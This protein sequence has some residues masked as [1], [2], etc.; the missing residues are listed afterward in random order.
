MRRTYV[1]ACISIATFV[2]CCAYSFAL[3]PSH[4]VSQYGHKSWNNRDGFP[5]DIIHA[6]VQ[7][8]D[9]YLWLGTE[10]GLVRFDG[11]RAVPWQPPADQHLPSNKIQSLLVA[12]DGTLWIGT[13]KGL[14]SWNG[15]KLTLYPELAEEVIFPLIEDQEG[16][17]WAGGFAYNPPGKLCK[18]QS[19]VVKCYGEDGSLGNGVLGLY[20]DRNR[21]LWVGTRSGLWRWKPGPQK[22]YPIEG[23]PSGIQ[24]LTEDTGAGLLVALH[25]RIARLA[26]GKL[27]T[28][29]SYPAPARQT[30]ARTRL[31]DRDGGLWFGT[32][33]HGLVHVHQ[34]KTDGF[35]QTEGLSGDTVTALFED[36]EGNVWVATSNGLDRFRDLAGV[37]YSANQGFPN[38]GGSV[39]AARDGSIW[40]SSFD[41]LSRSN[42][43]HVT[44]FQGRGI[45]APQRPSVQ[46]VVIDGLPTSEWATLFQDHDGRIWVA[47]AGG[48]GYLENRRFISI[49]GARGGIVYAMAE[50]SARN[51]WI[52][53][54]DHGLLQLSGDRVIRQIPWT[55]LGHKELGM[56]LAIDPLQGGVWLGFYQGG[57]AYWKDGQVRATYTS[58]EGLGEGSISNL[59][60]DAEG[61]LWAAT[62]GGLSRLKNGHAITLSSKNGLP[63]NQV[64]WSIEDNDRSLWLS[65]ACG[66]VR[67]SRSEVRTWEGEPNRSIQVTVFDSSDGM[68]SYVSVPMAN[69]KVGKSP[70]GKIWFTTGNGITMV[71]PRHLPFN[72]LPPPVHVEQVTVDGKTHDPSRDL[73]LP[74]L[75]QDLTID[76]T[77]LSFVS[78]EKVLFR[79]KLEGWDHDWQEAG[80]RR[81]AIYTNLPPGSYRFQV[82]ACNNSGVWN[83][84]GATLDFAIAPA[85]YQTNWFRGIGAAAFLALVWGL[86]Q[87]RI[88]QARRQEKKLRDVIETMPT[89]AWTALPDGS[90]D[91]VNRFWQEYTGL[92]TEKTVGGGWESAV[93]RDDLGRHVEK[94][95]VSLATGEVF[96]NEVRYR[97]ASD[98]QYRWFLTRA[99]P[100]RDRRGKIVKWYGTSTEIEDRK[101]AEQKFRGLLESAPDAV[102][103][104]NR[105]GE[106]VLVNTQLEKLFGYQR[107]ELLGKKVETLV[108]ARL[109]EKHPQHRA[110]FMSEPRTRPMG[111]GLELCGLRKDGSEFPVEISLSPLE[112]EEGVL[113]SSII[114]D[115]SDRRRAEEEREKLRHLEAEL[116]HMNRLTMLGE[117]ASSLAHEINQPISATIT[118]AN[119]CLRWLTHEPPDLERARAAAKRIESDGGRAADIIQRLRAFYKTGAPPQRELVDMNEVVG[120]MLVL[121]RNEVSRHSISVGTELSR[122]LPQVMADRVQLQQVLM[123]LMLNGIEA[124]GDGAGELTVRSQKTENGFVQIS[125]GDTGVGLP[126]EKLD[127]IFNAFYTTKP[128][129]TGMGLA[130]SRSIIEAHGGRLWA[131]ANAPRGATFHFTVPTEVRE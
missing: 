47:G 55:R 70:D 17:V 56:T 43:G 87:L 88:Q 58:A 38:F 130:I 94:W 85:Y 28:A 117:L 9:G 89:F 112:T 51:I 25:G 113:I 99:V 42:Q 19:G 27:Q 80:S 119:A 83:E 34:G 93:H 107:Q 12:R 74:P 53:N 127:L 65:M 126:S 16:V 1:K 64:Q 125:V 95:R 131:T 5:K 118:S 14:A 111:S 30:F 63:C 22:F 29:Y 26:N 48:I 77:A 21:T 39:L 103:V 73:R 36:R 67:I 90:V 123:N 79:Y 57:L 92:S 24:A 31:R 71:N 4:D 37:T 115:I 106:I 15:R 66:L 23:E 50:D 96:E 13:W 60:V 100:L 124:M 72:N 68:R 45:R 76:Y 121:L 91:F 18:I 11:V 114:R 49:G 20:E 33:D 97:R 81:Q 86:Y 129:G 62:E 3:D 104:V 98:G 44:F 7:T 78:P 110:G 40:V 35:A 61:V 41:G 105:E 108:P 54:L 2:A 101:Q 116:A 8:P 59:R 10:F 32:M 102:A 6:I 69:P 46:E 82:I 120:E 52:A 109:R 122:Q 75:L 128:Q 84:E